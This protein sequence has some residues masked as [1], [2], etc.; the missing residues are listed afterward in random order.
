MFKACQYATS[1]KPVN[2]KNVQASLQK[3]ITLTIF[4]L[5]EAKMEKACV[6]G[7][8]WHQKQKLMVKNHIFQ[9]NYNV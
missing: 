7:G 5:K 4:F 9:K 8:M 6:D 2:V 3:T 1:L